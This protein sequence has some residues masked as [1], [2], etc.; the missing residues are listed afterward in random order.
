MYSTNVSTNKL[1]AARTRYS[2]RFYRCSVSLE[3]VKA[4]RVDYMVLT[5]STMAGCNDRRVPNVHS[6]E[7]P[8]ALLKD[9]MAPVNLEFAAYQPKKILVIAGLNDFI[10]GRE[11]G[12][13]VCAA[14]NLS[15][16]HISEP[17]RPY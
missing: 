17:T 5:T 3:D 11:L 9:F 14:R 15:L 13:V 6:I 16:I 10:Q 4:R 1:A 7:M 2:R 12:D 8:G